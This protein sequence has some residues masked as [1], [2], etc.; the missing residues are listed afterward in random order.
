MNLYRLPFYKAGHRDIFS[1]SGNIDHMFE[2][3][4]SRNSKFEAWFELNRRYSEARHYR[5]I[6]ILVDYT[7]RQ[8]NR[9]YV[10]GGIHFAPPGNPELF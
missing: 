2:A 1:S 9:K 7:W 3:A 8:R 5:Y 10:L 4:L 6:D